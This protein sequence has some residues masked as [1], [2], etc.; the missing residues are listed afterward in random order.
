MT[1]TQCSSECPTAVQLARPLAIGWRLGRV[2]GVHGPL[3]AA[4]HVTPVGPRTS[5]RACAR[6]RR[7]RRQRVLGRSL[8]YPPA[9]GRSRASRRSVRIGESANVG[10]PTRATMTPP[11]PVPRGRVTG[12]RGTRRRAPVSDRPGD[13]LGTGPVLPHEGGPM[14]VGIDWAADEHAVCIIEADGRVVDRFSIAHSAVG[15]DRLIGRLARRAEPGALPVALERPDGRL[16]DRLLE[17]GHPVVPVKT[18]AIKAWREA[19]VGSGAKSDCAGTRPCGPRPGAPTSRRGDVPRQRVRGV[20]LVP[21]LDTVGIRGIGGCRGM[22]TVGPAVHAAKR[23]TPVQ[24]GSVR[25]LHPQSAHHGPGGGVRTHTD[26]S[27]QRCLRPP[28]LPFR[29]SGPGAPRHCSGPLPRWADRRPS[30]TPYS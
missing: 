12:F 13:V 20:A 15:F 22:S 27:V 1:P 3:A 11:P 18:T 14:Y 19:E 24:S 26:L 7:P 29:H 8:D 23:R 30:A 21:V 6:G 25:L 17:A 28:R 4:V 10:R 5:P 16:V 9:D 2:E